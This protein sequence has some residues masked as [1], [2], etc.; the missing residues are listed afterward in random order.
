MGTCFDRQFAPN[1]PMD[2]DFY[3]QVEMDMKNFL[4]LPTTTEPEPITLE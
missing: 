1:Q 2:W 4:S 3:E